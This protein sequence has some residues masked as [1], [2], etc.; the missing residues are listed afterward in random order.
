MLKDKT[1]VKLILGISDEAQFLKFCENHLTVKP[2]VVSTKRNGR[3]GDRLMVHLSGPEV[4]EDLISSSSCLVRHHFKQTFFNRHLTKREAEIEY[5][6]RCQKRERIKNGRA[7]QENP[8]F[9]N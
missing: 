9:Q 8:P 4:V 3:D 2:S 1:G 7:S 5:N 6:K